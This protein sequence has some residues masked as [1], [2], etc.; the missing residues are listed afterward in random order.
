M[1]VKHKKLLSFLRGAGCTLAITAPLL[2]FYMFANTQRWQLVFWV[3]FAAIIAVGIAYFLYNRGFAGT[4]VSRN[5]LP[6]TWSEADKDAF[7][8]ENERRFRRSKPLLYLFIALALV[9]LYDMIM[10]FLW[11]SLVAIFPF[12]A[13][14]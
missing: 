3:Y 14:I 12:L 7:F 8:E 13:N 11:D 10:L 6:A 9:F 5:Q 2:L 1:K 4:R